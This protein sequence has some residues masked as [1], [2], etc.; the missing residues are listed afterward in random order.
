[1]HSSHLHNKINGVVAV[2][3]SLDV[4]VTGCWLVVEVLG[5]SNPAA[6]ESSSGRGLRRTLRFLSS[7]VSSLLG[8]RMYGTYLVIRKNIAYNFLIDVIS[9]QKSQHIDSVVYIHA[10]HHIRR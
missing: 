4:T 7:S 8:S 10:V 5:S 3:H 6:S 9:T 2:S 1:M